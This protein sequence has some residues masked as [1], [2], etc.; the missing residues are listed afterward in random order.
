[1]QAERKRLLD[2]AEFYPK[3]NLPPK[4][5][6]DLDGNSAVIE[7]QLQAIANQ[8]DEAA[9]KNAF[10]DDELAKLRKL[11]D[12]QRAESEPASRR[13]TDSPR[14][15]R[16]AGATAQLGDQRRWYWVAPNSTSR[17]ASLRSGLR[18]P[19]STSTP[20]CTAGRAAIRSNQSLRRG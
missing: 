2:E 19:A 11:W 15:R 13:T 16:P 1:M 18:S 6:R 5:R 7:A 14:A 9:Q 4:L 10:Y 17:S 20:R 8:K 3:G 12:P